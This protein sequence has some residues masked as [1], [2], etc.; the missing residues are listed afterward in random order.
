MEIKGSCMLQGLKGQQAPQNHREA[1]GLTGPDGE[2]ESGTGG[3][4]SSS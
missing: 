1:V 2:A 4:G 3:S